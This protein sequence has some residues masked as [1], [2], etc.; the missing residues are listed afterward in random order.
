MPTASQKIVGEA[1]GVKGRNPIESVHYKRKVTTAEKEGR[2][3]W[4]GKNTEERKTPK[5]GDPRGRRHLR[6]KTHSKRVVST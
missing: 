1:L 6:G 3:E 2:M 5:E 4:E